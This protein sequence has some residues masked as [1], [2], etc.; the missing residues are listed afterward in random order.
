MY[1]HGLPQIVS[2][3]QV[4]VCESPCVSELYGG[5]ATWVFPFTSGTEQATQKTA[6]ASSRPA[7]RVAV[8]TPVGRAAPA[9]G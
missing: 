5:A 1:V 4:N 2:R 6:S 7:T 8:I 3:V 9:G